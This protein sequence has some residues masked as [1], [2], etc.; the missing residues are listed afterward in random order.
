MESNS[1]TGEIHPMPLRLSLRNSSTCNRKHLHVGVLTFP[2]A[3]LFTARLK[4]EASLGYLSG[5]KPGIGARAPRST[6]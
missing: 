1:R 5:P 3:S 2:K 4:A 6:R